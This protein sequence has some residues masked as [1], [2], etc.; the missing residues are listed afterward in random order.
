MNK[1]KLLQIKT[2]KF[3]GKYKKAVETNK[4]KY[5]TDL[6]TG[7]NKFVNVFVGNKVN[8]LMDGDYS[9]FL[10]LSYNA[11]S[12]YGQSTKFVFDGFKKGEILLRLSKNTGTLEIDGVYEVIDSDFDSNLWI[13][14][15]IEGKN[16]SLFKH[17]HQKGTF[18]IHEKEILE[19]VNIC[20]EVQE[21]GK[22][23]RYSVRRV[24]TGEGRSDFFQELYYEIK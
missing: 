13:G 23:F 1:E 20:R 16:L 6:F 24:K 22:Q 17:F 5:Y 11:M 9:D 3:I 14:M 15:N 18:Y 21:T 4:I 12:S 10:K 8:K 2:D 7:I 19:Y